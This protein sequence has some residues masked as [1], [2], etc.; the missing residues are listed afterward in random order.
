MSSTK[1]AS[2]FLIDCNQ[3]YVSCEQVFNPKLQGRPVVVLSNND[4]CVVARSKEAKAL[5]IPMGAPAYQYADLFKREKVYVFSSN[6]TLYG[7]MSQRVMRVLSQF[8]EEMEEYSIDEAFLQIASEDPI[9][10]AKEIKQRVFQWTGIPVSI[11]IG[12]TKTLAK[13]ANDI[14]KKRDGI[15]GFCNGIKVDPILEKLA[16]EEIWGIGSRLGK[17]LHAEGIRNAKAFKDLPDHWIKQRFSVVLLRTACELRGIPCLELHEAPVERKSI[18]RSRSFSY[19]VTALAELNEALCSYADDALETLRK[20]QLL[21]SFLTVFLTTSPF[22]EKAYSNSCTLVLP[23]PTHY[24]PTVSTLAKDALNRIYRDGLPYKKTGI[25]LGGLVLEHTF[26]PDL[27]QLRTS[28]P[29]KQLQAMQ[30]FD[31]VKE[32][33]GK[34]AL[35]FASEGTLQ[36]W[37]MQRGSVSARFTTAWN[38]LLTIRI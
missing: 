32:R 21:P 2:Y 11:G 25:I 31:D 6:Y 3:F 17:A 22:I 15:F 30:V 26:Q 24:T 23:E 34:S 37:R 13:V 9:T 20:E 8:S 29:Q 14:A 7:D 4:G 18:T 33:Y 27:F 1:H 36:K 19:K 10:L 35:R 28:N 5:K 12:P 16:P 38:E